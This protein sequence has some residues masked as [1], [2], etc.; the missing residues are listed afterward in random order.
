MTEIPDDKVLVDR[1]AVEA[2]AE[3]I[4]MVAQG[5]RDAT[6]SGALTER[7]LVLL[8]KGKTS[9]AQHEIRAVIEAIKTLDDYV[10]P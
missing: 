4:A 5:L 9:L 2:L 8:I 3:N 10:Q 7:A 6:A 1:D